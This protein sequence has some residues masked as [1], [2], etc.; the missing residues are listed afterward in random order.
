MVNRADCAMVGG[1]MVLGVIV[2]AI[3]GTRLPMH[4][5]H[6]L[7]DSVSNPVEAHVHCF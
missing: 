6:A 7:L 3:E 5:E 2:G 1:R 4:P